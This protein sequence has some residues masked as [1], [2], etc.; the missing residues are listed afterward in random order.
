VEAGASEAGFA[1]GIGPSVRM[2]APCGLSFDGEYFLCTSARSTPASADRAVSSADFTDAGNCAVSRVNLMSGAVTTVAGTG[3][4]VRCVATVPVARWLTGSG[5]GHHDSFG[6]DAQFS[7][8]TDL[9]YALPTR[10]G[11]APC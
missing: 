6:P 11:R 4:A 3:T 2:R 10:R 8:P 7:A 5:Q 1:D 9:L